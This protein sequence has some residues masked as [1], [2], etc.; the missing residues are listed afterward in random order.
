MASPSDFEDTLFLKHKFLKDQRIN[1]ESRREA[2]LDQLQSNEKLAQNFRPT[3]IFQGTVHLIPGLAS[4]KAS[5]EPYVDGKILFYP[6][7][8]SHR[9]I[10]DPT[11]VCHVAHHLNTI[12]SS[13][14]NK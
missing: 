8:S 2:V 3:Q 10:F 11:E 9:E 6:V 7:P 4:V 12:L 13:T 1:L 14:S 5:W